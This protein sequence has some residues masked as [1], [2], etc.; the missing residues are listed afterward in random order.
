MSVKDAQTAPWIIDVARTAYTEGFRRAL[1]GAGRL[2][3]SR[4]KDRAVRCFELWW[5]RAAGLV[6]VGEALVDEPGRHDERSCHDDHQDG[7]EEVHTP[8]SSASTDPKD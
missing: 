6:P 5:D 8:P 2:N 4:D 3:E 1:E 7:L